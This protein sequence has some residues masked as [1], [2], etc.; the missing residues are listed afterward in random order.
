MLTVEP[1][2]CTHIMCTCGE[3]TTNQ[4]TSWRED[5]L[6]LGSNNSAG[7]SVATIF[8]P[9]ILWKHSTIASFKRQRNFLFSFNLT[10]HLVCNSSNAARRR[11][12][13]REKSNRGNWGLEFTLYAAR[14]DCESTPQSSQIFARCDYSVYIL[15]PWIQLAKLFGS[16]AVRRGNEVASRRSEF[17]TA[18]PCLNQQTLPDLL[19]LNGHLNIRQW[20][21][22]DVSRN[23]VYVPHYVLR[24]HTPLHNYTV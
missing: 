23:A 5:D 15:V 14:S 12:P 1:M 8:F 4:P 21:L 6:F 16:W 24:I 11:K 20:K 10:S 17:K 9:I 22:N 3:V 7:L 2:H 18:Q 19:N 13:M